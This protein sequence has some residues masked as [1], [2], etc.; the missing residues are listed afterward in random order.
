MPVLRLM[1]SDLQTL[2]APPT[3][4]LAE[5][6]GDT[7]DLEA[8]IRSQFRFLP[9]PISVKVYGVEVIVEFPQETAGSRAEAAR[10]A[11]KA[12]LGWRCFG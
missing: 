12:G 6:P 1:L 3:E 11:E 9:D 8:R 4:S 10:L 5:G 7:A 2:S